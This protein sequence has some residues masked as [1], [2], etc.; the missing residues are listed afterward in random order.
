MNYRKRILVDK[1]GIAF[2]VFFL[3]FII[4]FNIGISFVDFDITNI[5]LLVMIIILRV[6]TLALFV[7][8]SLFFNRSCNYVYFQNGVLERRGF[9]FGFRKIIEVKSIIHIEKKFLHLDGTY[10]LL[11]DDNSNVYERIKK[12]SAIFIPFNEAGLEFIKSFWKGEIPN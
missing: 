1:S 10:Y 6:F 9:F 5:S 7:L 3:F 4:V 8:V 2:W 12:N 11:F